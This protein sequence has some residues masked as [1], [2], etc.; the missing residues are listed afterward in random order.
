MA[1]STSD[2]PSDVAMKGRRRARRLALQ[3][4]YELD[5]STHGY[6]DV[7]IGRCQAILSEWFDRAGAEIGAGLRGRLIDSLTTGLAD[8]DP[9]LIDRLDD[10]GERRDFVEAVVERSLGQDGHEPERRRLISRIDG[11]A[12]VVGQLAYAV[13]IVSGVRS[14]T[15]AI[16]A[17]IARIAPEWPVENMAPVDR[18]VL[19]IAIWEIGAQASPERV[20]INEAV[21]LAREF[22]GESAR[23]MVN[24]ALGAYTSEPGRMIAIEGGPGPG[25]ADDREPSR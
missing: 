7:L 12:D 13:R 10:P 20:A 5:Q 17:V 14:A 15:P 25:I 24:G 19:R 22:S 1:V 18:N 6:G 11:L 3:A 16:D 23:R 9:G 8:P 21:E 4:L 2:R